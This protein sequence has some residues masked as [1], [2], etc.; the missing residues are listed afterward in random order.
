MTSEFYL[1][2]DDG[3]HRDYDCAQFGADGAKFARIT[4]DYAAGFAYGTLANPNATADNTEDVS[5][6]ETERM[7]WSEAE[8]LI[9][10]EVVCTS[11]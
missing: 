8:S 10:V 11:K 2:Q 5:T 6:G 7:T 3:A 1:V 4:F 9:G